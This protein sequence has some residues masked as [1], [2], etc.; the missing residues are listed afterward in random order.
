LTESSIDASDQAHSQ[1]ATS[2]RLANKR[3]KKAKQSSSHQ[4]VFVPQARQTIPA[5][6]EGKLYY[7]IAETLDAYQWSLDSSKSEQERNALF[8]SALGN[9]LRPRLSSVGYGIRSGM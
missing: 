2:P 3:K 5:S 8:R 9:V 7:A 4:P 1:I 6:D